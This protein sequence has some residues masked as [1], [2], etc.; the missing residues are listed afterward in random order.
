MN[1]LSFLSAKSI[2]AAAL[3]LG[4]V[5]AASVAQAADGLH[6]RIAIGQ[7]AVVHPVQHPVQHPVYGGRFDHRDA[8]GH[9]GYEQRAFRDADRDG[10]PNL[11]DRDSRFYDHRAAR[12]HAQWGDYDRDGVVNQY[13]RAPHNPRWR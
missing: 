10:V 13:D 8:R 4:A 11:Y 3:A 6:V 1:R 9:R 7:P 2:A 5:G 12:R